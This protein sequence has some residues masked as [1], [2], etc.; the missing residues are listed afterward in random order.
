M[1]NHVNVQ[2][3]CQHDTPSEEEKLLELQADVDRAASSCSRAVALRAAL[4][5]SSPSP[6]VQRKKGQGR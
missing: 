3:A 6:V 5:A 4:S 1:L 2:C